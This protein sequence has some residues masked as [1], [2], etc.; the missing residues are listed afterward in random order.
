MARKTVKQTKK[1][2][3][4]TIRGGSKKMKGGMLSLLRGKHHKVVPVEEE[5]SPKVA[6]PKKRHTKSPKKRHTKSV[7]EKLS[8]HEIDEIIDKVINEYLEGDDGNEEFAEKEKVRI[9]NALKTLSMK[10]EYYYEFEKPPRGTDTL[11]TRA[12][13]KAIGMYTKGY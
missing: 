9:H 12:F 1:N 8:D 11:K 4:K 2:A 13:D 5:E 7:E 6:S 10:E 3:R